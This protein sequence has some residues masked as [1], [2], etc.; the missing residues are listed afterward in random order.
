M[1]RNARATLYSEPQAHSLES[2][3]HQHPEKIDKYVQGLKI[4]QE[5]AEKLKNRLKEN[6]VENRKF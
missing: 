1:A 5:A 6:R 3:L 2:Y 4:T